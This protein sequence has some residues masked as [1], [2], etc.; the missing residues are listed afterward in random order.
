MCFK[1]DQ[2]LIHCN[3]SNQLHPRASNEEA[4]EV[5]AT[6]DFRVDVLDGLLV[7]GFSRS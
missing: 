4:E 3:N 5:A 1:F 6:G 7:S 2:F